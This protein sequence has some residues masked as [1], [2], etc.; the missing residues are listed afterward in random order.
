MPVEVDVEPVETPPLDVT[1]NEYGA[2]EV[3]LIGI[4]TQ[5]RFCVQMWVVVGMVDRLHWPFS[6]QAKTLETRRWTRRKPKNFGLRD[7][8]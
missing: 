4:S 5:F 3:P 6:L 8:D 1:V 7:T 2:G